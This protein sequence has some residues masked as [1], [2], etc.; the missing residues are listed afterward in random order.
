MVASSK[1][2][3]NTKSSTEA[4]VVG[5]SDKIGDVLWFKELLNEQERY[6]SG[7]KQLPAIIFQDNKSA[8]RL[9][10]CGKST[11]TN[12]KHINIRYFFVKDR[13]DAEEIKIVHLGTKAMIADVLT[14]PLQGSL[15]RHMRAELLNDSNATVDRTIYDKS[16]GV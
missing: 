3:I 8:I 13:L 12:T 15:F 10:E 4:E 14:K 6:K 16:A 11:S 5:L 7:N 2:K 9:M 1:Q